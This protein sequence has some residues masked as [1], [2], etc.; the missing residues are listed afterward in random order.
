MRRFRHFIPLLLAIHCA[1]SDALYDPPGGKGFWAR[2]SDFT[3]G[4]SSFYRIASTFTASSKNTYVYTETKNS[5][6]KSTIDGLINA[7][8]NNIAPIENVWYA[9]PPDVDKNGKV[10]LLL[11]DIQDGYLPGGA[12]VA[13]YFDP[14]NQYSDASINATNKDYHSNFAEMLYLDTYPADATKTSFLATLA[15]E[16]QHLLQFGKYLRNP[17]LDIEP[18]WVDEGLAE[19]SS[20]LTGYGPQTGRANYFRSALLNGTPLIDRT[21]EAFLLENYSTAYIYFRYLADAY[22]LGG[23]AAIFNESQTGFAG[24]SSALQRV[25]T[26]LTGNCGN[27]AGLQYPHFTC[28][29]RMMWA[30]LINGNIGDSPAGALVRFNGGT[31]SNIAANGTYTYNLKPGNLTYGQQLTESLSQGSYA[32]STSQITGS[33]SSYAPR[34]FKINGSSSNTNFSP[35]CNACGLTIVAG[36]SYFV[37]FN[38]DTSSTTTH[39]SGIVDNVATGQVQVTEP[40]AQPVMADTPPEARAVHWHFTL[41]PELRAQLG[42]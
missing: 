27:T 24:I 18:R 13:G 16:Y 25:D 31:D 42:Q 4:T 8:E 33:L 1:G 23:I 32:A 20:D 15:H 28:S 11:L 12:Y 3:T 19:V 26:S 34:L 40:L 30:A 21:S 9:T 35:G 41:S 17:D 36:Q 14:L 10:I 39:S 7:F 38:H 2:K 22:G 6:S 37:V 29:Y 5:L